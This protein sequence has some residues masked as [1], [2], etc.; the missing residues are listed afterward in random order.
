MGKRAKLSYRVEQVEPRL[1]LSADLAMGITPGW[2]PETE[3]LHSDL[4][5]LPPLEAPAE[6]DIST[7]QY[8]QSLTLPAALDLEA[9]SNLVVPS[10]AEFET[11]LAPN[12]IR[13]ELIVIDGSIADYHQLLEGLQSQNDP[14]IQREVHVIDPSVDG[15]QI[16]TDLLS[17]YNNL[18]A[19][20]IVSHGDTSGIVLGTSRLDSNSLADYEQSINAWS[21]AL[22]D[23]ADLLL[24]GCNLAE[25]EEGQAFIDG[26]S[27][28]TGADVAASDD[29]TGHA[30]LGGDWDLEYSTGDVETTIAF[31]L[32][33]QQNWLSVLPIT[34]W[35]TVDADGNGMVDHIKLTASGAFNDDFSDLNVT[36][37]G[38]TVDAGS[39]YITN[40]GAGGA[41]DNVFYVKLVESGSADTDATPTVT[42]AANSN[43]DIAGVTVA[44]D[45]GVV[46]TDK[47][48]PVVLSKETADLN[49]DGF[50]DAIQVKFSEAI[51]DS[52]VSAG[53]WDVAGVTVDPFVSTTNGD[54]AD[55]ADIYITFTD[56]VLDTGATPDVTYTQGTLAD[57][58]GNLLASDDTAA[59]WDTDW[60]N[61]TKIT[62]DNTNSAENLADF[63]VL[64]SL[65]A[66]DVDFA[67][68]KTGG[69]DIRFVDDD[70][71]PLIYEIESWDDTPGS[72]SATVW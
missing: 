60:Q 50:I 27:A 30:I 51:L 63:P 6:P 61:R 67:K 45:A 14:T 22:T 1:L 44:T 11:E 47:A 36:V 49:G 53:D 33:T 24:Y 46:A 4:E 21:S 25:G 28:L 9:L 10:S 15:V 40:L 54:T 3:P 69:E 23:D 2:S 17:N 41:L 32:Q 70:G 66:A 26:L 16:L 12:A 58:S 48:A 34:I 5:L 13:N 68:I 8:K 57:G 71:K 31:D 55:D 56:G 20:H 65:T 7:D 64:V 37:S 29:I 39:S 72:E 42:V 59:W 38:Y 62:F 18:D 19:V 52:T 35:E 43:L